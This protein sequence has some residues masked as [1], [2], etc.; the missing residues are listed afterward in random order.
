MTSLTTIPMFMNNVSAWINERQSH[1]EQHNNRR[2]SNR[3]ACGIWIK[4]E[5]N[6]AHSQKNFTPVKILFLE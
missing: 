6:K 5:E 1:E 4:K 3:C 2:A